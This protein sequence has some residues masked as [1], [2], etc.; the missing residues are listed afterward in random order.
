VFDGPACEEQTAALSSRITDI[1][2]SADTTCT[3]DADCNIATFGTGPACYPLC[4]GTPVSI[5]GLAS[6]ENAFRDIDRTLCAT[7]TASSCPKVFPPPCPAPFQVSCQ[8][9]HCA[10]AMAPGATALTCDQYDQLISDRI[11]LVEDKA[12]TSCTVDADCTTIARANSCFALC[13]TRSL[14]H[15]GAAAV[16]T[17][18]DDI[19]KD[20]C[21]NMNP[22]C[23]F[24]VPPC[25]SAGM[26]VCK[27]GACTYGGP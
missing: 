2:T 11:A 8:A 17:V 12:D 19:D 7:Y 3:T 6:V 23:R 27:A 22:P 21:P 18:L 24:P 13:Q 5:A 16:Q 26:P 4:G 14:S 20:T 9:G 1:L 15:A 25:I 10:N